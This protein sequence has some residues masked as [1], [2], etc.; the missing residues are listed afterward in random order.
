MI[1]VD[2]NKPFD[3][4]CKEKILRKIAHSPQTQ[5]LNK[6]LESLACNR[7]SFFAEYSSVILTVNY[8]IDNKNN[9]EKKCLE[10]FRF[11]LS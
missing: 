9:Y 5:L 3:K 4:K 7:D 6:F 8:N 2:F 11:I 1:W 10:T